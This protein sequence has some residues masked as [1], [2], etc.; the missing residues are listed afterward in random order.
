MGQKINTLE[1]KRAIKGYITAR[2]GK[3]IS[4]LT[5]SLRKR[6]MKAE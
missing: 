1:L 2:D 3:A 5:L 6:R 4:C